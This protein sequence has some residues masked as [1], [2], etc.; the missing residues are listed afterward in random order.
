MFEAFLCQLF[1]DVLFVQ[2]ADDEGGVVAGGGAQQVGGR[3]SQAIFHLNR[4]GLPILPPAS[5]CVRRVL[6]EYSPEEVAVC[7]VL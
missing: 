5:W 1:R 3:P 7:Q 2:N 4:L 6:R